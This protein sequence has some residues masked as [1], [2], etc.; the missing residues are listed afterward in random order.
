MK[1]IV[2]MCAIMAGVSVLVGCATP[3]MALPPGGV[4]PGSL[5]SDVT[6]PSSR[7][8]QTQIQLS[9]SDIE[10]LGPVAVVSESQRI[11]G[12]F[13]QG[14]NGY[15]KLLAA[16]KNGYPQADAVINVMWD[17]HYQGYIFGLFGKATSRVTGH[18]I[19]FK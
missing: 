8:I 19:K 5:V 10:I 4:G 18:A 3:Y 9:R 2:S 1:I 11:L 15:G 16:A 17:T 6:V 12:M 13:S 14:D 7:E